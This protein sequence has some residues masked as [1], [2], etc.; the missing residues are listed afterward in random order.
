MTDPAAAA[1]DKIAAARVWLL[2][3][4]P[5]FG[6]LARALLVEPAPAVTAFRLRPDDRLL[7]NPG[8]VLSLP[9]PALTARLAHL[10]LHAAL[11]AFARRAA[12]DPRR[13]N[14]AHD[15]AIDPLL[16]AAGLPVSIGLPPSAAPPGAGAEE[17]YALLPEGACPPDAWCDIADPPSA[18]DRN[19]PEAPNPLEL[20]ARSLAWRMRLASA[21]EEEISSGGKTFGERPAWLDEQVQA[22]I[23]PPPSFAALLS[24]SISTL[25]RAERSYLRPSRRA[26][27]LVEGG[28]SPD[29]VILPGRRVRPAGRLA[30]VID[31][32]ASIPA[33]AIARFLGALASAATAEGV[34]EIRLVQ[35]DAAVTRDEALFTGDLVARPITV[36]GRGGTDF[37]PALRL[38][39]EGARRDGERCTAV[40]LTD[41][42]GAFPPE[43]DAFGLD[44]LWVVAARP[45]RTP[46]FG[47]LLV[48]T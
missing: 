30:A 4:K 18:Q 46:P 20:R 29:L 34:D 35:A 10:A 11:G 5:F 27:A 16:R 44:V 21:L 37:G 43:E 6:V 14:A 42:S 8:A 32:S 3:E 9:F 48:M 12:R 7:V 39:A 41:L 23:E 38:L 24:R 28:C 19:P 2:K 36:T 22:T 1:A 13:W 45:A 47:R 31:T 26:G 33:E 17:H 15:L 40:Y 25:T